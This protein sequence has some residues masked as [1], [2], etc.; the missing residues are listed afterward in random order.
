[1]I[2]NNMLK[3]Y[4]LPLIRYSEKNKEDFKF[5]FN[6]YAGVIQHDWIYYIT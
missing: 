5:V 6:S 4:R 2:L 3:Y 1:M